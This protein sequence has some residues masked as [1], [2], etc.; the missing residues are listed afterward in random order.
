MPHRKAR[1]GQGM[2]LGAALLLAALAPSASA[3]ESTPPGD[4]VH[5]QATAAGAASLGWNGTGLEALQHAVRAPDLAE[6]KVKGSAGRVVVV[7]AVGDYEPAH[8]CDRLPSTSSAQAFAAATAYI[9]LERD[10]ALQ[11]AHAGHPERAVTAL[12]RALHALQDCHSHSNVV[13]LDPAAQARFQQA[14][15]AGGSLP[16]GLVLTGFQP[17]AEDATM[18]PGD[19]Y[20]HGL[21]ARDGTDSTPD[22]Q[23]RLPDGRTKFEATLELAAATTRSFLGDFL[24]Q[25]N[26]TERRDLLA[27]APQRAKGWPLPAPVTPLVVALLVAG[28]ELRRRHGAV[29]PEG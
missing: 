20:P 19:P 26:G 27:V 9:R 25:L 28:A 5:D 6:S 7:D 22:A 2:G 3:F 12:G 15:Q 8:H 14:L 24:A 4:S 13:D 16:D 11:F 23:A 21:H 29:P 1:G 17:G 10:Q 18:P